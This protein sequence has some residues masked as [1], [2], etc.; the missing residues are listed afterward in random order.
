MPP[1][2]ALAVAP[3]FVVPPFVPAVP[4]PGGKYVQP[5]WPP[6]P[7]ALLLSALVLPQAPAKSSAPTTAK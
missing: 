7:P 3:P 2:P 6:L 4:L 5:D 1:T